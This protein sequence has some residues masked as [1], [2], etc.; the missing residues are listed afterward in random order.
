MNPLS[1]RL[2]SRS[3]NRLLALLSNHGVRFRTG[4][5]SITAGP[6]R[7]GLVVYLYDPDGFTVELFEPARRV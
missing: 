5:V 2:L 4:P 3:K 1:R 7:G 6:N